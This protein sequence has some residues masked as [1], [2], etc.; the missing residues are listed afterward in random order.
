MSTVGDQGADAGGS[1]RDTRPP[2][3]AVVTSLG[4]AALAALAGTLAAP[5]G[6]GVVALSLV[7][8]AAGSLTG[9]ARVLSWGAGIG[10]VGIAV[11]AGLGGAVEPLLVAAIALAVAWDVGDHGLSV[12][13]HVGREART[14]QNVA[15]HAGSSL[16]V[17]TL[18]A[19]VVY[20][21]YLAAAGGQPVT[22]VALLLFGAVVLASAFR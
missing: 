3:S 2:V 15:V 12:G 19:A 20:G 11:A 6:G 22:A 9:S 7:A 18:S 1:E 14:R 13:E 21:S 16:L 17:G 10:V 4:A 5:I 8:F